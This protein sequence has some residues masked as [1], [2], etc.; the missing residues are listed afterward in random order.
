V[1][2]PVRPYTL[3]PKKQRALVFRLTNAAAVVCRRK[4]RCEAMTQTVV[5]DGVAH[6]D[7]AQPDAWFAST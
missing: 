6:H 5:F 1:C 4:R 3:S 2:K 7:G